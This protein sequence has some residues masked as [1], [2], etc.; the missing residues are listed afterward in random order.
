MLKP[1]A[2]CIAIACALSAL[3]AVAACPDY[4]TA[5]NPPAFSGPAKKT[6]SKFGNTILAG[7]YK[8][9]H[10]AHDTIVKAGT[11]AT[12]TAKFD[13]DAVLHKDL[14]GER[15]HAYLYGTGMSGW[16]YVGNY[17]TDSDGKIKVPLGTRPVG[18]YVVR[19][20]VEGDLSGTT[21]YLSVVDPGREAVVFDIDGTLT[22]NDFEAYA[23]YVGVKTA[24]AYY[25]AP[26]VVN[27]YREKG[28]QVIFLTARPYWVTKDGLEWL[29]IQK[30][31]RWH[32]HSN[33]Y[34][35]GPIP[36][37]TQKF[38]TDYV[39][40]LRDVV[41]LN[42]VRAYGNATT[43]IAAYADGGIAKANTYIIGPNAGASGTQPIHGEYGS[44]LSF[45]VTP[46]PVASCKR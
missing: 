13:Y 6:F 38:K 35:G 5:A 23:D 4:T 9:W 46:T 43:D 11:T 7:L 39:R 20:V 12:I 24:T 25:A 17:L 26:Q 34:G 33:P 19:F 14:E 18:D 15:V 8:P 44:H 2:R 27:A 21:G 42:I 10:M 30:V 32:Y 37:D 28:Y 22:I 45:V 40:H 41:G 36:P 31:G 3:P 29:D 1:V 16:Q